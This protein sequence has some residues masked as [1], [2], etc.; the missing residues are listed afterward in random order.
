MQLAKLLK[1][2]ICIFLCISPFIQSREK[3]VLPLIAAV[4]QCT[5][6]GVGSL[7]SGAICMIGQIALDCALTKVTGTP[8]PAPTAQY[9]PNQASFSSRF[10]QVSKKRS[11]TKDSCQSIKNDSKIQQLGVFYL[12]ASTKTDA[13]AQKNAL[14]DF[15]DA[16][17][18][19]DKKSKDLMMSCLSEVTKKKNIAKEV[20]TE[21]SS[22]KA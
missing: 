12:N 14:L 21:I 9:T 3:K 8:L 5:A 16:Y 1:T 4:A 18:K 19:L 11:K 13:A 6:T 7:L 17:K 15:V 22:I 20:E 10:M 2:F